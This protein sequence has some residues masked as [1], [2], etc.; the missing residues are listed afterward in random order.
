MAGNRIAPVSNA[1]LRALW[2]DPHETLTSIAAK[3]KCSPDTVGLRAKAMG[4]P[5]RLVIRD[6]TKFK[7]SEIF[8]AMWRVG[9]SSYEMADHFGVNQAAISRAAVK[10]ELPPRRA[11]QAPRM[12]LTAF[13]ETLLASR[14]AADR[15]AELAAARGEV[16]AV[17]PVDFDAL[18]PLSGDEQPSVVAQEWLRLHG[19]G[20][21]AAEAAARRGLCR[22]A[23]SRWAEGRGISWAAGR[24]A[25]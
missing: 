13:L 5:S 8:R 4:L 6:K 12:T 3:A 15:K 1:A 20:L 11:G 16:A 7:R 10:A 25:A 9:V 24:V 21:T 14:M 22:R 18:F 2:L 23:A 17:E 19:E